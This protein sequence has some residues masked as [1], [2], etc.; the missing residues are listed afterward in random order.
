MVVKIV[1]SVADWTTSIVKLQDFLKSEESG[2]SMP[3]QAEVD[4]AGNEDLAPLLRAFDHARKTHYQIVLVHMELMA[5][6]V[7][8]LSHVSYALYK[9]NTE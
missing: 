6:C 5:F 4:L 8:W 7:R 9:V 1:L 3:V 2:T